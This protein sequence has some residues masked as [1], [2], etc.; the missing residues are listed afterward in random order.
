MK[1]MKS[2]LI[3]QLIIGNFDEMQK[4]AIGMNII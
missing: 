2:F 1:I 4:T 3:L